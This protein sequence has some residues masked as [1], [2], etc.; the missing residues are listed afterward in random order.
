MDMQALKNFNAVPNSEGRASERPGRDFRLPEVASALYIHVRK[1]AVMI[2]VL[3]L[4]Y[5]GPRVILVPILFANNYVSTTLTWRRVV[6]YKSFNI[7]RE[8]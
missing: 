3:I 7:D 4:I 2:S 6:F 5:V 1:I 8:G